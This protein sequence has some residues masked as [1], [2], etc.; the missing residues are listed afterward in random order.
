[1]TPRLATALLASTMLLPA[2]LA[3]A[4]V[5]SDT[6]IEKVIVTAEKR[7]EDLQ[8]VPI[9]VQVLDSTKLEQLNISKF[10]D[11]INFLPTVSYQAIRPGTAQVYMRGVS[12]GG[13]GNHSGSL[14]SVGVYLDEQPVT[15]INEVLDVHVYDVARIETLVGPQGTLFGASSEAGTLRIITNKPDPS[16]FEAGYD[17][18][19]NHVDHG[20]FGYSAE[21]YANIPLND[22]M[23]IRLVGW[24]EHDAGYID[25]V[26]GT[27]TYPIS[28]ITV[29]NA[30]LVKKNFNDTTTDGLRGALR[31]DL[32]E[33]W[34]IT[35][36]VIYQQEKS[37]GV[38]DFDPKVGDLKVKRF[39]PDHYKDEWVQAALTIQ[40][41]IGNID[42]TYAGAYM[43]RHEHSVSD[44][45]AYSAYASW[46][47]TYYTCY[48]GPCTD[49]TMRVRAGDNFRRQSHELRF[50]SDLGD[51][52]HWIAGVFYQNNAWNYNYEW[53][54]P[55]LNPAAVITPPDD[56]YQTRQ[57]RVDAEWAGFGEMTYDIIPDHL[58]ATFGTRVFWNKHSLTGFT[59]NVWW[60]DCTYKCSN[61]P[62]IDS[63]SNESG[64]IFKGNLT[65]TF[66]DDHMIY[67][68]RSEGYRPGGSNRV[69]NAIGN[70]YKP[71][72]VTNYELGWKT[73]W[74]DNSL[75][76]N[77]AVYLLDWDEF[78]YGVYDLSVSIL[79]TTTNVGKSQSK[80]AELEVTWVPIDK[81]TL[82]FSG[83]YTDAKLQQDYY[84]LKTDPTPAAPKG[85]QMPFVPEVQASFVARY[86][87]NIF[88]MDAY[89]QGAFS[90]R[91]GSY[92]ALET[93][94]RQKQDPYGILNL[95]AGVSK[96]NWTLDL[97]IDNVADTRAQIYKNQYDF[98]ARITTNQP[99]T[100]G[101]RFGQ[102]F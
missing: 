3:D 39:V 43:N 44:Y 2:S 9:S 66:D 94:I 4:A 58:K 25:N 53:Q 28:G 78:Q 12:S 55:G 102:R 86:G 52:F 85:T 98:N 67:F 88:N 22:K 32:D 5:S 77:G 63:H 60:P 18:E 36:S 76:V 69:P 71:D 8:K 42:V 40:G 20:D 80:G 49:P 65:Y 21:G 7:A 73:S 101:I 23:A 68:T 89:A 11:F 27:Q 84:E 54:I 91:G 33:N 13:D 62:N 41:K 61:A 48:F 64:H 72:F 45:S 38:F 1:M 100:I 75:R 90:Y 93:A 97:F 82:S 24:H 34:T 92:N 35:P 10:N 16:H 26:H 50:Q 87:F 95:S 14:P 31:I 51:R 6:T 96:D 37:N 83:V 30:K 59:G 29:D 99:R 57:E 81:L 70:S 56:Q 47:E 17:L 74:L 46:I 15:T 19:L 79:T